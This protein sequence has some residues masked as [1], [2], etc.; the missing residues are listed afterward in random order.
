MTTKSLPAKL[1]GSK[2]SI[3]PKSRQPRTL[4]SCGDD[5]V[6]AV[7]VLASGGL[8]LLAGGLIASSELHLTVRAA[9]I[10]GSV[11]ALFAVH[12]ALNAFAVMSE[13]LK[14]EA[15][16]NARARMQGE[17]ID[18][19]LEEI[20]DA[21][22]ELSE[23][24][25]RYRDLLDS[26]D[27]M[28]SRCDSDGRYLF[29]NHAFCRAFGL[30]PQHI[31][32]KRFRPDVL[33]G[34]VHAPLAA[35]R[36]QRRRYEEL[37]ATSTGPRWIVW[38]EHLVRSSATASYEVQCVGRDVTE[39]REAEAALTE[40]RDQ[41]ET[42][43]R[44]KSRFL[45]AMS[46]EI[47]TP[48]NGILG[49]AGLLSE[50]ELNSEQK[51]YLSAI[52]G[53]A[54][55]LL[56]LIDE[57]LDFSKIEAGKL[58]LAKTPFSLSATVDGAVRLLAPRAREKGLTISFHAAEGLPPTVVGDQERVR[59]IVLN[60]VSNAIKFT[61]AGSVS[62]HLSLEAGEDAAYVISVI[63][64]GI[65][66]LPEDISRLFREFEQ[67]DAALHRRNGGTG[68]GLAISQRLAR[69]MGGDITANGAPGRGATFTA[70]LLLAKS[71][72]A[73]GEASA[74]QSGLLALKAGEVQ[75][76]HDAAIGMSSDR[77]RPRVL[78]AEDNEVNALLA[79]R[80]VE[81]ADCEPVL[82]R[83]GVEAVEAV[84]RTLADG[85]SKAFDLI[86]MDVFMPRLDG[87]QATQQILR[88]F[89]Q[90][91]S[92]R[93]PPPIVALTANAFAEDRRRCLEAGMSDYLAKPFDVQDLKRLLLHWTEDTESARLRPEANSAA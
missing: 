14:A 85:K 86:L 45:A 82:V 25:A 22:W 84:N 9:L 4:Q 57:I 87:L 47:R 1:S 68:L 28:I 27:V 33:D 78:I 90:L 76:R 59:Q 2:A 23:N 66:L 38:E 39:E 21:H 75:S 92:P 6:L 79:L 24:E 40:A 48:M 93:T 58:E 30:S 43:N 41:A 71:P 60:L 8:L 50:T 63:D 34:Q 11:A 88:A 69:A 73:D 53:S 72:Q 20:K 17:H 65:G 19:H 12:L 81:R 10:A 16:A 35:E 54:H 32:G 15:D 52:D 89:S 74:A 31:I 44:A 91:P 18:S 7:R 70:R 62:V 83:D 80:V 3:A 67:A 26:Q 5:G 42:A 13:R 77:K 49:M 61:D 36:G 56:A 51:T 37:V 29:V 64:T 55:A 46:H